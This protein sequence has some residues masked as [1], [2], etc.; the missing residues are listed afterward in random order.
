MVS[1]TPDELAV[2]ESIYQEIAGYLG[3]KNASLRQWCERLGIPFLQNMQINDPQWQQ[4]S[5]AQ[6][7]HEM[8]KASAAATAQNTLAAVTAVASPR[9][10]QG[11]SSVPKA[12]TPHKS[13]PVAP[14]SVTLASDQP[15]R[16]ASPVSPQS[17]HVAS[18]HPSRLASPVLQNVH[19]A[20]DQPSR[21]AS[22][23]A[24]PLEDTADQSARLAWEEA[25]APK[26]FVS[27]LGKRK[28]DYD[29]DLE[30]RFERNGG[31]RLARF[32]YRPPAQLRGALDHKLY[33]LAKMTNFLSGR[34]TR[35]DTD[36]MHWQVPTEALLRA[37]DEDSPG[38][39]E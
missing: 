35:P 8:V 19:V 24:P 12:P 4:W 5:G 31:A 30:L 18:D 38:S 16:L 11:E 33:A 32:E 10:K 25:P 20:S 13:E 23:V 36:R 37:Q 29:E 22:P 39:Q 21:L 3:E 28:R 27:L 34:Q 15:S 17:V 14:Q 2:Y 6:K 26:E 9:S 7:V 1:L